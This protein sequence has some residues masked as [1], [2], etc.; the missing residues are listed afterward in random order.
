M[1]AVLSLRLKR[2]IAWFLFF[3]L[4]AQLG[5]AAV[6]HRYD[7]VGSRMRPPLSKADVRLPLLQVPQE[8]E[9]SQYAESGPLLAQESGQ[10]EPMPIEPDSGVVPGRSNAPYAGLASSPSFKRPEAPLADKGADWKTASIGGPNQPEMQSFTSVGANNMVDLFSGDFSYN[11]PLLDVGGYPV[12]IAYHSGRSMDEDASWVGLGWNINPGSITRDMRGVPDDFNGGADTV[13]KTMHIKTNTSWG[14][15]AGADWEVVGLPASTSLDL[16]ASLGVFHTTYT[17]WGTELGFNPSLSVASKSL[18][19]FTGKLG[20]SDNSQS[21]ITVTPG[22]G[23]QTKYAKLNDNAGGALGLSASAAYNSRTGLKDIQLNMTSTIQSKAMA[24]RKESWAGPHVGIS[25]AIPSYTPEMQMA[26]TNYN[27]T[28]TM[29]PGIAFSA[30]H[31]N[32][33]F[34]GY[35]GQEYIADDDT[36]RQLPVFGYLNTQNRGSGWSGLTDLNREKEMVY[37]ETPAVPHIAIPS[38]TYDIFSI[39]G[40]GNGGQ[41]RAY[42]GDIG[43]MAD[44]L[45]SSKS[46]SG[47]LSVDLGGG[48]LVHGGT[49]L[50]GNFSTTTDGPW[51][52]DNP[53]RNVVDFQ[54][55]NGL[56]EAAYFRN[57]GEK[58]SNTKAYYAALGGD[59]TVTPLLSQ[60]GGGSTIM[61]S[62]LLG[63]YNGAQRMGTDTLTATNAIKTT[64]D[65]RSQVIS[66]LTAQEASVAGLDKYINRYNVNQFGN[67][68]VSDPMPTDA[69]IGTGVPGNYFTNNAL[70]GTPY[71]TRQDRKIYFTYFDGPSED[72]QGS[73]FWYD[74]AG[75]KDHSDRNFPREH[76]S[77]RWLG[78]LKAPVTGNYALGFYMDDGFRIWMNDTVLVN[79]WKIHAATFDSV[80]VNLVAGRLYNFRVEYFQETKRAYMQWFWRRPDLPNIPFDITH[81]LD[82]D[83]VEPQFFYPPVATDTVPVNQ[84]LTRE[85][86]VNDFRKAS[87][88]SEID[89]LNGDGKRYVYGIPVYNTDQDEVSFNVNKDSGDVQSGLTGFQYGTDN[90]TRNQN[91]Q[92]GYYNREKM[93]AYA[94]SF[95]LTG[96]L[97]PDYVDVTGDGISDDDIGDAVRF[98]YSKT[99]GIGNPFGWRAPYATGKASYSEGLR[100]YNRDDK[101]HYTYGAKELWY[102]H[103]IESKTMIAT[104]TLQPRGDMLD[105]D[106]YGNKTNTGKAMCLKEINLY[107]KADFMASGTNATPIK[108]VHFEYSYELCRGVNQPV[109]DSGKLTLK[110]IWFTYNGNNRGQLNPYV[111]NYHPNNPNYQF[112]QSDKWGTYKPAT[113]N[114]GATTGNPLPNTDYPYALQDSAQAAYNASAWMLDSI[115][116][117]SGGRIKVNFES[118]DYAYV[119]NKRASLMCGIAG[120]GIDTSGHYT[121]RL[122]KFLT[123][124]NLY[125]YVKVPYAVGW[126]SDLYSRYLDGLDTIHFRLFVNMPKDEFGNGGEFVPCYARLDRSAAHWYGRVDDHTIWI[127]I[128]GVNSSGNGDG[129]NSPLALTAINFLRMNLGSKAYPGSEL[130]DNRGIADGIKALV[131][132]VTNI[133]GILNGF[134]NTARSN[135]WASVVDTTSRSFV[136]LDDPTLKKYGGGLRVKSILIYDNWNKMTGKKETVYGQQYDY[137]TDQVV[138]GIDTRISSGVASWEP[139][140]GGEENPFH[141]PIEYTDQ[142]SMLAPASMQYSEAPLGESFY[143]GPSVGYSKVRVRSIHTANTRSSNGWS[144]STFYTSYDFPTSW[145]YTR[146]DPDTKKRYKPIL[147]NLL[148]INYRDYLTLSQGFKVELNDMNGKPRSEATYAETDSNNLISYTGYFYKVDNQNVQVKHLNNTVPTIDPQ[149]NIDA[150]GLIG[151]DAELMT[152]MRD[153]TST[154][155]GANVNLNVDIFAAGVW[156][157][158]LPSLINLYQHETNQFRTVAFT[159]VIQ[160]YGI[161]DS[162]VKIDKGSTI[163]TKNLLYDAETGDA[164]LTRTQNEFNDSIFSFSYPAHWAYKRIG[165]AYQNIDAQLSHIIVDHGHLIDITG[166]PIA[167]NTYLAPGDE[168]YVNGRVTIASNPDPRKNVAESFPNFY[169]LWVVDSIPNNTGTPV[170][171]IVDQYGTPFSSNDV[172]LKVVRSGYRNMANSIGSVS[173]LANPLVVDGSGNYHLVLDSTRQV[174]GGGAAEMNQ[175]WRVADKRRTDVQN[176][177]V[178]TAQDSAEAVAEMCPCIK[179]F[180]DWLNANNKLYYGTFPRMTVRQIAQSAGISLSSCPLL[181]SNAD[182]AFKPLTTPANTTRYQ[183]KLGKVIFTIHGVSGRPFNLQNMVSSC[184]ANQVLY[185]TPGLTIPPPDTVTVNITPSFVNLIS[186]GPSCATDNRDSLTTEDSLSDH[187]MV[188]NSLLVSGVERNAVSILNFGRLDRKL[189]LYQNILSANLILHADARGHIPGTLDSANSTRPIDSLGI[190]LTAPAGWFLHSELDS[191]LYQA[192]YTPW[193]RAQ[194][195][196]TVFEDVNVDATD[197]V[198]NYLKGNFGSSTLALTKGSGPLSSSNYDSN[199]VAANSV[200]PYLTVGYSNYYATFYSPKYADSTRRP[201]LQ[202]KYLNYHSGDT[203]GAVLEYNSTLNCTSVTGRSCYSA[204]TDTTVNVYQ[205]GIMG[206]YRPLRSYVYYGQRKEIDPLDTTVSIR[207]A[208]TIPNF[209]PFW[210]YNTDSSRWVPSYDSSRWVWNSQTTL[211]NRKGFELENKDPL[212]RYNSGLYGY[213]LT[214]PTA[215]TQNSR[216]QESAF[217]GFEDYGFVS[218][219]CDNTCAEARPFDFSGYAANISDSAAHTGLYSLRI[220]QG[221]S[222]SLVNLPVAAAPDADNPV[223]TDT[224]SSGRLAGQKASANT[225]LPP[226]KPFAGKKMLVGAWVKQQDSCNCHTYTNN[227]LLVSFTLSG[228]GTSSITLSTSGNMI[229]GWQRYEGVVTIPANATAMSVT[230]QASATSTTYFDD[231]RIHPFNGE[232]KSYVYNSVNLRLMA[233]LDENNYATFYEY[234]DDG[235]LVRVKKETERGVMTIKETRSSLIKN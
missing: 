233:E 53:L 9:L 56:F 169:H 232:M 196:S 192:Y 188:E 193:Y 220:P 38:Y 168:L 223:L 128:K 90:T 66:Y 22:I 24:A 49:D 47:A 195:D 172:S 159:K 124:D 118:D 217:E 104:F 227:H 78:R 144:E 95:L 228:G 82:V 157:L 152:D 214:V 132:L 120:L 42:R 231:I 208:G 99:A 158:V 58:T 110:K 32:L 226:F 171:Y 67:T 178:Y 68:C 89:V 105:I 166:A 160:R 72:D 111:F 181:Q 83:S 225:L 140:V 189:P 218:N 28:L 143:P 163:Y 81:H 191:I 211:L 117:P 19:T 137:A 186:N 27:V 20:I 64:R 150:N 25:F 176:S 2:H 44:P 202:V 121:N 179:P 127:K 13:T 15:T 187:L 6:E 204:V 234:D 135:G 113:Q 101:G 26:R 164:I 156:P 205:Y 37:R 138:N 123:G 200:P 84:Y 182:S 86:R 112:N 133:T 11:I 161:L 45:I 114:P 48:N 175:L 76:Y 92:S 36:S 116:L 197:F 65:K 94:H 146:L 7:A 75:Y 102:L 46:K 57:P 93:P 98:N 39:N 61:A 165:P 21:G 180:F 201:V 85:D 23:Y 73:P 149:G 107:S 142:V 14:L 43:F 183:A 235:T 29:K 206:D 63:L 62:N 74:H 40:E 194:K 30:Q 33:Y 129:N 190:S 79:D 106:E 77:I 71:T 96:I 131:S 54:K 155:L 18:G 177:C 184:N 141:M 198:V 60:P 151:K 10:W 203:S 125:V 212:G 167:A 219:S 224:L 148:R 229:E 87:H 97:S 139:A 4:Y 12:N 50:N 216:Y 41:F 185:K 16:G 147:S 80:H 69:G 91:G 70:D 88:I 230:M 174:V 210:V 122:Y 136:R 170:P 100:T 173:T 199:L 145:D 35:Y 1:L 130:D 126:G 5:L 31:P 213:G 8:S 115:Q 119:Q 215:V 222:I 221:G 209:Q 59:Y 17:G 108:T 3:V 162:V 34:Q 154:M 52:V 55:S 109:N 103:T 207:K 134:T 153:E 51:L